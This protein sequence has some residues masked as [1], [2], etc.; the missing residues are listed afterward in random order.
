MTNGHR[1]QRNQTWVDNIAINIYI[2]LFHVQTNFVIRRAKSV[3]SFSKNAL[4]YQGQPTP[5]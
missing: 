1:L 3:R 5:T 2:Y 4:R